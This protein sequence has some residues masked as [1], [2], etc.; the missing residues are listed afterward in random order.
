MVI[1]IYRRVKGD[2]C[3]N[4]SC[5]VIHNV[6]CKI[7]VKIINNT[8]CN[9]AVLSI[10]QSLVFFNENF[11]HFRIKMNC[12]IAH[13]IITQT[14][15]ENVSMGVAPTLQNFSV[16][17]ICLSRNVQNLRSQK[18]TFHSIFDCYIP[19]SHGTPYVNIPCNGVLK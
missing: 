4:C 2:N 13:A 7:Y 5:I 11:S 15:L 19:H 10:L 6:G 8:Y 18:H 9:H 3:N 1:S 14:S 16:D 17:V 12:P